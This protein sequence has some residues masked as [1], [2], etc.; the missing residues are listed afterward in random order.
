VTML[1]VDSIFMMPQLG[2]L[3]TVHPQAAAQV[4][5]RDCLIKLGS[6]IAPV[7]RIK[8]GEPACTV[9]IGGESHAVA[10]GEIRLVPLGVGEATEAAIRPSGKL[11]AGAGRGKDLTAQVEG[12]AVGVIIDCRGRPL[13]LPDDPQARI[14]K[15]REWHEALGL[16]A[17]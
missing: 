5:D 15:L 4:F 1:A 14:A 7:G 2:V 9:E 10:F 3:S 12:G 16:A 17:E 6:A 13:Q 11:D 8:A